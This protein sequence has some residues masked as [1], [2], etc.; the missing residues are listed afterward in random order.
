MR[1]LA[2]AEGAGFG[3]H[4]ESLISDGTYFRTNRGER[5][6]LVA[7]GRGSVRHHGM[8]GSQLP[9]R[10]IDD[11]GGVKDRDLRGPRLPLKIAGMGD[12]RLD[13]RHEITLVL[14]VLL[15]EVDEPRGR[16]AGRDPEGPPH[17]TPPR[18]SSS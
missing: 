16:L 3:L 15:L 10:G 4:E 8:E 6:V 12:D 7:E 1:K 2:I 13:P 5:I 18:K 17:S 11:I 9:V 14:A